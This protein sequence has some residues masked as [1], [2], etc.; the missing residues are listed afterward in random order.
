[1]NLCAVAPSVFGGVGALTLC[2]CLRQGSHLLQPPGPAS[3]PVLHHAVRETA[4]RR[5]GNQHLWP[6]MS[7]SRRTAQHRPVRMWGVGGVGDCGGCGGV[8]AYVTVLVL[9]RLS[10]SS[11]CE[12]VCCTRT[13]GTKTRTPKQCLMPKDI[14]AVKVLLL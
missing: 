4:D 10:A 5:G 3:V 1:M 11:V 12:G 6:G 9:C 2:W 14:S 7:S 8:D 13:P